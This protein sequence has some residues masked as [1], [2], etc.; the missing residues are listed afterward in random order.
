[1]YHPHTYPANATVTISRRLRVIQKPVA[2][3]ER[4]AHGTFFGFVSYVSG[5]AWKEEYAA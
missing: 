2:A 5:I 3:I 4:I 1:M